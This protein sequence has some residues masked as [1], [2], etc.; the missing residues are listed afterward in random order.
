LPVPGENHFYQF[1]K[2]SADELIA[3]VFLDVNGIRVISQ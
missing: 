1:W 2:G 3:N